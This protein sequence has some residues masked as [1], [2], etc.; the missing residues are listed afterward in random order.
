MYMKVGNRR[1]RDVVAQSLED[2]N[3]A[4]SRAEKY[5]I[6]ETIM[7][8]IA[9]S[10]GSF[11]ALDDSGNW[12]EMEPD[13]VRQKIAHA[14]RDTT[15]AKEAKK[16]RAEQ[17][18]AP[19]ISVPSMQVAPA[20][21][22]PV[23]HCGISSLLNRLDKHR[24]GLAPEV[25]PANDSDV[26]MPPACRNAGQTSALPQ[27][28]TFG[29]ITAE[30]TIL[31]VAQ[32]AQKEPK[33]ETTLC[34]IGDDLNISSLGINMREENRFELRSEDNSGSRPW[35]PA[36][37]LR[38]DGNASFGSLQVWT[39]PDLHSI[40]GIQGLRGT[41][42]GLLNIQGLSSVLGVNQVTPNHL[43]QQNQRGEDE[44]PS[45]DDFDDDDFLSK[46]NQLPGLSDI[47]PP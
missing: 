12:L 46:I 21:S 7:D 24:K 39:P 34:R 11:L 38:P 42:P 8:E 29:L 25:A 22:K 37:A 27:K 41:L 13:K 30:E 18:S 33:S 44:K 9:K 26:K 36:G 45:V 5:G 17:L 16:A 19:P 4:Q 32:R 31:D 6:V 15:K 3:T 43:V 23:P 40:G 20:A 1:F 14:I 47:D 2:Y 35:Y 10:G 28:R